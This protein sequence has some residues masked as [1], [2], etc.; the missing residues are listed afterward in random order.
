MRGFIVKVIEN[1]GFGFIQG[2]DGNEYFFHSS[3]LVTATFS[4]L[5][6]NDKV[7]FRVAKSPKGP[8]AEEVEID[9]QG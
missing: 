3:A 8:R 7:T 4:H 2:D 1:K 5:R 6:V 9:G